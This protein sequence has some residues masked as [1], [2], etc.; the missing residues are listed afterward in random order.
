M[1]EHSHRVGQ[2]A[3]RR[4][5]DALGRRGRGDRP[6]L[7]PLR[8]GVA[9]GRP[10]PVRGPPARRRRAV[11]GRSQ[12]R[13][14][15]HRARV[16]AATRGLPAPAP[17]ARARRPT[18]G[19][20][21]GGSSRPSRRASAR[22]R[23]SCSATPTAA[24]SRR[25]TARAAATPGQGTRYRIDGEIARG[26]MGAVL[27]GRDPDLGRDVALKVLRE[28]FRDNADMV[29]R[30]VEEAQIGGQFQHPGIVPIYELGTFGDRRPFFSMKLVKGDTLAQLLAARKDPAR[31]PAPVAVDLRGG[32]ADRR[33]RPRPRGDPP[34]PEAVERD[35]RRV[36]RGPGD[37]LGPG[38][39][40]AP[41]RCRRR[42]RGRQDPDATRRSSPRPG[43]A[44]PIPTSRAPGRSWARRATW[45]PSRPGARSSAIDERADVF[46]LGSILCEILTGE[47]AFVGRNFGRDP[48]QGR[49][50]RPGRRLG[51]ARR[52]RGRR[53]ADRAG[54]GLP[55]PRAARTGPHTAGVVSDRVT[56]YLAGVQERLRRAEL[57]RVEERARRRLTTV[58]AA[59]VILLGLLGGGGY[60]WNQQQ[61]AD[62]LAKTARA[63]D[64]ALA[65]ASRLLRRGPVGAAGRRG[66]L[67]GGGRGGEAGRG[68]AGPG[69]GRRL[70]QGPGGR[71]DGRRRARAGR[72]R[73]EGPADR[74]R[75]R[76][77]GGPR[78]GPGQP[79]RCTAT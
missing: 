52:L 29:R 28:D 66:P 9:I 72:R 20:P 58:A 59:A 39:G 26:G 25:S 54:E 13:A 45:P 12:G 76:P 71:P 62:R 57:E 50:G 75:P 4:A 46:A 53:R 11:P 55:G 24:P 16:A 60:A 18:S 51:P 48:A 19:L 67:V 7:R 61:K 63:V 68:A 32:R 34:R 69:R 37:G 14:D 3:R 15:R 1:S 36:R 49:A 73:R 8:G 38:Q 22:S 2:R 31:R 79:G 42:C 44:R 30:F 41:R 21:D 47:P 43:A 77:A 5:G 65:D 70:A 27:K 64:E 35:G 6:A 40:P 23:T 10:A 56:A 78:I 74:D 33:L 17:I